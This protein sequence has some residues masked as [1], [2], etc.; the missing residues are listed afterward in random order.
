[1]DGRARILHYGAAAEDRITI[2]T[3][4]REPAQQ[5]SERDGVAPT[6]A[7]DAMR[8]AVTAAVDIAFRTIGDG[9]STYRQKVKEILSDPGE[10]LDWRPVEIRLVD[11]PQPGFRAVLDGAVALYAEAEHNGV[12]VGIA[13]AS[14]VPTE[15]LADLASS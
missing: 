1:M 3:V 5:L 11:E 4:S 13:A 6:S 8:A 15:N 14:S 10:Q 2:I 9:T 7:E 12:F